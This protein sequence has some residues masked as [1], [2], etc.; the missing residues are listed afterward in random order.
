MAAPVSKR[1]A[2][3]SAHSLSAI[4]RR[5]RANDDLDAALERIIV[6]IATLLVDTGYGISRIS[7]LTK[8]AFVETAEALI[9]G[10]GKKTNI[11]R[12]AALTG[13]TRIEVSRLIKSR[14]KSRT[15]TNHPENR[16]LRVAEAWVSDPAF[17]GSR[18]VPLVL[19]FNGSGRT[20]VKLVR[21]YSGDIPAR[22]MLTEM[23]RLKLVEQDKSGAIR[24][25]RSALRV[26]RRT[27]EALDAIS[28][29]VR[30]L[31]KTREPGELT[32]N[33]HQIPIHVSSLPQAHAAIRELASRRDALI[34]GIR[35]LST[36]S[37]AECK[38]TIP[39]S[40]AV[41]TTDPTKRNARKKM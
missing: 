38:F 22:A 40:V 33:A 16:V 35:E 7:M 20:F 17:V 15:A 31:T 11:A 5:P 28:P 3:A 21:K 26:S 18:G 13:L 19:P 6:S 27:V 29:W 2:S 23:E 30:L 1:K 12:V 14:G 36:C 41:A 9:R 25:L 32:S 39:V 24:L 8:H 4:P 34:E 37:E 10:E